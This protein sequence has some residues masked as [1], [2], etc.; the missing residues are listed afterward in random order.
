MNSELIY[1]FITELVTELVTELIPFH[2]F[3]EAEVPSNFP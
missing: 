3:P 1:G 2:R